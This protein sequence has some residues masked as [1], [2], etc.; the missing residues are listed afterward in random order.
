M[1]A[2]IIAN[3]RWNAVV[4]CVGVAPP[5]V[6]SVMSFTM[7]NAAKASAAGRKRAAMAAIFI[8]S[9]FFGRAGIAAPAGVCPERSGPGCLKK[10]PA[11]LGQL[12]ALRP[13]EALRLLADNCGSVPEKVWTL[14]E[15]EYNAGVKACCLPGMALLDAG[16]LASKA[17]LLASLPCDVTN[18]LCPAVSAGVPTGR[19]FYIAAGVGCGIKEVQQ[20]RAIQ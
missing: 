5:R 19:F 13:A 15:A 4:E 8:A 18:A 16:S 2:L 9:S 17:A 7:Y 1:A 14:V 20:V 11:W 10:L 6:Q 12:D 3:A